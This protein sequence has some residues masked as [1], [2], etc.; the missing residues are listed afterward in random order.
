MGCW[1]VWQAYG[2]PTP[3]RVMLFRWKKRG[4]KQG[5]PWWT[6][7]RLISN[8]PSGSRFTPAG[9]RMCMKNHRR[10]NPVLSLLT[11]P[12]CGAV[13]LLPKKATGSKWQPRWQPL[14]SPI[15]VCPMARWTNWHRQWFTVRKPEKPLAGCWCCGRRT[16]GMPKRQWKV[17]WKMP[18]RLISREW[19]GIFP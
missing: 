19:L 14:T 12:R 1:S 5:P 4:R 15:S 6:R 9:W 13:H 16:A 17:L 7:Q 18:G 11:T 2:L 8:L 10:L 3:A